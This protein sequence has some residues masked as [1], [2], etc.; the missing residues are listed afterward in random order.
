[1]VPDSPWKT[2]MIWYDSLLTS[3]AL[4][5]V[6]SGLKPLNSVVRL[7]AG[8]VALERDGRRRR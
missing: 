4:S 1:M 5:V 6:N 7:T 3:S 2:W 8:L